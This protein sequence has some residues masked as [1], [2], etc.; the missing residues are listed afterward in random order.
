MLRK[1]HLL[2]VGGY[3]SF[4]QYAE[5]FDLWLRLSEK[6][7]LAN[8]ESPLASYRI[9]AS[10]T[11]SHSFKRLAWV[12]VGARVA[13]NQRIAGK[14]EINEK[15]NNFAEWKKSNKYN[16][17]INYLLLFELLLHKTNQC[18][19]NKA[20]IKSQILRIILYLFYPSHFINRLKISF[21]KR[22]I[23]RDC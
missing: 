19:K 1:S 6:Y 13:R 7:D 9:H 5:D 17:Q 4:F 18:I 15:Y 12:Q 23:N 20:K 3:R 14:A 8:I 11:T 22:R 10:Q 16:P 2:Q 21:N